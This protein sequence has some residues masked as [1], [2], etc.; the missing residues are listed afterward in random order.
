MIAWLS[1]RRGAGI[2]LAAACV[3]YL[4]LAFSSARLLASSTDETMH[5]AAGISY[6]KLGDFRMNPEHPQLVKLLAG[7]LAVAGGGATCEVRRPDGAT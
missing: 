2:L 3:V 1:S 4:V 7:G 6:W 5:L